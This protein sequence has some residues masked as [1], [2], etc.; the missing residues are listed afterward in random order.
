MGGLIDIFKGQKP[1]TSGL[2]AQ[3]EKARKK[4]LQLA[5]EIAARRR[6]SSGSS[7]TIFSAVEGKAASTAKKTKL[8]Q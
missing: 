1:D 8:G 5:Q 7:K 4:E 6:L 2:E 3:E